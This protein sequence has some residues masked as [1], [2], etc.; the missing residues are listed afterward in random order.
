MR[1]YVGTC[2][3]SDVNFMGAKKLYIDSFLEE[4]NIN[5]VNI[6]HS[7]IQGSEYDMLKSAIRSIRSG[8]IDYFFVSTHSEQIH[9]DCMKFLKTHG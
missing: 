6:L 9:A 2:D 4:N 8:K 5:H 7:D 1:G 3:P